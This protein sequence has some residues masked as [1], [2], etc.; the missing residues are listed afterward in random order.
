MKKKLLKWGTKLIFGCSLICASYQSGFSQR[1]ASLSLSDSYLNIGAI[2]ILNNKVDYVRKFTITS[3][4]CTKNWSITGIPDWLSVSPTV[5]GINGSFEVTITSAINTKPTERQVRLSIVNDL[6]QVMEFTQAAASIPSISVD[7][8]GRDDYYLTFTGETFDVAVNSATPWKI[9]SKPDFVV[10]SKM[11]GNGSEVISLTVLPNQTRNYKNGYIVFSN[12]IKNF[13]T[14]VWIGQDRNPN[15]FRSPFMENSDTESRNIVLNKDAS[16]LANAIYFYNTTTLSYDSDWLIFKPTPVSVAEV[17][18]AEVAAAASS[19]ARIEKTNAL[20]TFNFSNTV[21]HTFTAQP[22]LTGKTRV[23]T[24]TLTGFSGEKVVSKV[25]QTPYNPTFN[26][27][28]PTTF[29]AAGGIAVLTVTSNTPWAISPDYLGGLMVDKK[30]GSEGTSFINWTIPAN[31]LNYDVSKG[32]YFSLPGNEYI[33]SIRITQIQ[34]PTKYFNFP[35]SEIVVSSASGVNDIIVDYNINSSDWGVKLTNTISGI[36]IKKNPSISNYFNMNYTAN[37]TT[38]VR[39]ISGVITYLGNGG[40]TEV[41]FLFKQLAE[42]ANTT[43]TVSTGNVSYLGG[44]AV[45][46]VSSNVTVYTFGSDASLTF[47]GTIYLTNGG[48]PGTYFNTSGNQLINVTV[49]GNNFIGDK[50]NYIYLLGFSASGAVAGKYLTQNGAPVQTTKLSEKL[51][52]SSQAAS[53]DLIYMKSNDPNYVLTYPDWLTCKQYGENVYCYTNS[54][55]GTGV[56]LTGNVLI[57]NFG[58]VFTVPAIQLNAKPTLSVNTKTINVGS[59]G[60]TFR[61]LVN[62]E[63]K[64]SA[65]TNNGQFSLLSSDLASNLPFYDERARIEVAENFIDI[66]VPAFAQEGT[67]NVSIM[68]NAQNSVDVTVNVLNSVYATAAEAGLDEVIPIQVSQTITFNPLANITLSGINQVVNLTATASSGLPVSFS[69]VSNPAGIAT[70]NENSL[71]ISQ[72]GAVTV[73]VTASQIGNLNFS[74]AIP[75]SRTISILT[76]TLDD[77]MIE[78]AK[79]VYPNPT[80][81]IL[82]LYGFE[83]KVTIYNL[84]GIVVYEGTDSQ[85]SVADWN[86]GVYFVKSGSK[87][88]RF[89]KK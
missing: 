69:V 11:E 18:V 35:L 46:T 32:F 8:F 70:L 36:D 3:A 72:T 31:N 48:Q 12:G 88:I 29:T 21:R 38:G 87:V 85:I 55:N 6:S 37:T 26:C 2:P 82:Y 4:N 22:N 25:Y 63:G 76:S 39:T 23:A 54:I 43:F 7:V 17:S 86:S 62:T 81:T 27:S 60:G 45:I 64:F 89:I 77:L 42:A 53:L 74:A 52:F 78:T 20:V 65:F 57:S 49:G 9:I 44:I 59:L 40:I 1:R 71:T 24:V 83:N 79:N 30:I 41:P 61:V 51:V 5:G 67:Y 28:Y 56:A 47:P 50:Y 68:D 34:N 15:G 84:V 33:F 13:N 16:N 66:T 75:V 19:F 73:T 80:E 58:T 10:P 14:R